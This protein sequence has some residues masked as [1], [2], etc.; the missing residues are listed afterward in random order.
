MVFAKKCQFLWNT[1][2]T[3]C[4][5]TFSR[6]GC[7]SSST[8]DN[9]SCETRFSACHWCLRTCSFCISRD[10]SVHLKIVHVVPFGAVEKIVRSN[11]FSNI[12][13]RVSVICSLSAWTRFAMDHSAIEHPLL[14][15]PLNFSLLY[16]CTFFWISFIQMQTMT[17]KLLKS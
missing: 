7:W 10:Q 14:N 4:I 6:A 16:I 1:E 13:T 12:F 3:H 8:W 2:R 5:C 9:L 11:H 15:L 17:N